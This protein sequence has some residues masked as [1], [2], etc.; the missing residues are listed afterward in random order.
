MKNKTEKEGNN[1]NTNVKGMPRGPE[2]SEAPNAEASALASPSCC[3][4][5]SEDDG[6]PTDR[7][8]HLVSDCEVDVQV[9]LTPKE[10]RQRVDG[11]APRL[12]G[13]LSENSQSKLSHSLAGPSVLGE[14]AQ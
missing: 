2:T 3:A 13:L 14:S 11:I 9:Q 8:V 6:E 12:L 1:M 4:R 5:Y 10:Y 7:M